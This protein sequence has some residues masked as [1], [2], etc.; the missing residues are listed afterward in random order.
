MEIWKTALGY[1]DYEV[2]SYGR[3][4]TLSR[5]VRFVHSVTGNE[6]FRTTEERLLKNYFNNRTGYF[7]VQLKKDKKSFNKTIHRLVAEAFIDNSKNLRDVNHIN[8]NKKDNR[9]E[10]LEWCSSEYNHAHAAMSGLSA[11][12]VNASN[13]ELNNKAVIGI[14]NLLK[15]GL[16][17]G[18]IADVFEVSRSL[19]SQISLG[20]IWVEVEPLNNKE[21]IF[22]VDKK[23]WSG[24]S[25][26]LIDKNGGIQNTWKSLKE[27]GRELKLD[28]SLIGKVAK[29]LHKNYKGYVFRFENSLTGEELTIKEL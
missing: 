17:H 6:H 16:S 12:G 20:Y 24:R 2:S 3:I 22:E 21:L 5:Q 1:N 4:R 29:G 7:F 27:A 18:L 25:I 19:I 11:S 8:G 10:N 23:D 9:L 26:C 15:M 28:P 13:S 14:K